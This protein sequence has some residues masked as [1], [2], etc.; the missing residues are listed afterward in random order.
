M[1]DPWFLSVVFHLKSSTP[2]AMLSLEPPTGTPVLLAKLSTN[3]AMVSRGKLKSWPSASGE[4]ESHFNIFQERQHIQNYVL[5]LYGSAVQII[6]S[7]RIDNIQ[8]SCTSNNSKWRISPYSSMLFHVYSL[9]FETATSK[10]A[11]SGWARPEKNI[12][13]RSSSNGYGSKLYPKNWVVI[14]GHWMFY[15]Q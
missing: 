14:S 15:V 6:R 13:D 7:R 12:K 4:S 11:V 8:L 2:S 5:C 9:S 10:E 1:I 3:G